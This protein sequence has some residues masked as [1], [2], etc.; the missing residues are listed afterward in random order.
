MSHSTAHMTLIP[1]GGLCNRLR[2]ILSVA[3]NGESVKVLWHANRECAAKWEELF[4]PMQ[5]SNITMEACPM[6][7]RPSLWRLRMN[8]YLHL[9]QVY[10]GLPLREYDAALVQRIQPLPA[11]MQRV[12]TLAQVFTSH[13]IGLHIRRTDNRQAIAVSTDEA[14]RR[15]I[16]ALI[17]EDPEATF[18]LATDDDGLRRELVSTYAP[19]I[20]CQDI[21]AERHTLQG[22]QAAVVDL[23]TLART[24]RII[25]SHWSSFS[26]TAAEIGGIPFEECK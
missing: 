3:E 6:R 4:A 26:S 23:W 9:P 22:M 15:R 24:G 21:P 11:L 19:R 10:S 13:T 1:I 2:A 17:E 16:D 20:T 5:F 14:F 18:F 12:E 25:G 7:H 8:K